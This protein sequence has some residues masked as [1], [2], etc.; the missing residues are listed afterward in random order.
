MCCQFG[1]RA[2]LRSILFYYFIQLGGS[3]Q[4]FGPTRPLFKTDILISFAIL[5][6]EP[7]PSITYVARELRSNAD[8]ASGG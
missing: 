6:L 2:G 7:F 5:I 1:V 8:I 3:F 4:L